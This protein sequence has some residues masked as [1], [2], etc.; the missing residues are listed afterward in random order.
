MDAKQQR[1]CV[2]ANTTKEGILV[3]PG[4]LWRDLD[5]R[6]TGRVCRVGKVE[7]GKAQMFVMV[8]GLAGKSTVVSIRRMHKSSTGWA[9]VKEA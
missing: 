9:I 4:Q 6:M 2:I 8:N 5:K 3:K 7:G 1:P